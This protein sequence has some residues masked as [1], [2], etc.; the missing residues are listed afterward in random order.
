M[1]TLIRRCTDNLLVS[2]TICFIAGASAAFHL[3]AWWP[4]SPVRLAAVAIPLSLLLAA[5]LFLRSLRP[6][7]AL[8]AFFLAG[9]AHTHWALQPVDDP[10]HIAAFA[11][12]P[13]KVTLVGRIL[14]LV[15]FNGEQTRWVLDSEAL[16]PHNSE[17]PAGFR[18]ILGKVRLAVPGTLAQEFA[19]GKKIMVMA[20]LDRIRNYQTPGA[21]D[22]RLQMATQGIHCSGWIH[23]P[24]EILLVAEPLR[25]GWRD[26]FFFP[27]RIRQQA[28]EF[29]MARFDRDVAGFYQALLIGSTVNISPHLTEIFKDNGCFH[30]LSISGLHMGLLG[31]FCAVL[32]TWLL[33]R[34]TWLLLRVHVP[35]LALALTAPVLLF[36]TFVAG[37]NVPAVRSLVTALLVLFAVMVRRQRTMVHLIAGAALVVLAMTPLAL[38][39]PSFQLSFAAVLAINLIY[40]RLPLFL[41]PE[42]GSSSSS[43]KIAKAMRVLQS[44]LYVSLAATAGTAPIL[45]YHFNRVSLIGP[46]MNLVIEPLLCLWALPCG[47]LALPLI[48]VFPGLAF[49]LCQ[50]GRPGI[51]L[52]IW[53]SEAVARFPHAS[54]WAITPNAGEIVC[55]YLI[56][57]LL[58]LP[59]KT[60][61]QLV[62]ALGLSLVLAGSF[63]RSLWLPETRQEMTV[64]FLDVGQGTCTLVEL[65]GGGAILID[66]GGYQSEQF[67]PGQ[68]LIAPFLWRQRLWRL[69]GLIITHPHRDH[70]NGLPFIAARFRPQQVIIN[71]DPGEEPDYEALMGTVRTQGGKVRIARAGDVL[72]EGHE[73]KI[74]CLGMNDVLGQGAVGSVNERS[75]VVRLQYKGRSVLFPGDIGIASENRLI[76]AGIALQSDVLL[77]PH[78]GSRHSAGTPFMDAVAPA[79]I[80]VSAGR[81]AQ[82]TH[83]AK[84]HLIRWRQQNI[85]V[86][87]TAQAGTVTART[88]GQDMRITTVTGE[89]LRF[90]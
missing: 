53:L 16:L 26:L 23:S 51:E 42:E 15:E 49:L 45:L 18:P 27:E 38:F 74:A 29:F 37:F 25:S 35:T 3:A 30:I 24:H 60:T 64:S 66:G 88:N 41:T 31:V 9:L 20:T 68:S 77:A 70:Y 81:R 72:Y 61:R 89:N 19:P 39:T 43:P 52:T 34:S 50:I 86:L 12:Q 14:S 5:F 13:T 76:R 58:L 46:V 4:V 85:P 1:E 8:F 71:G 44:L 67:D 32:F 55:Y 87:V 90:D 59:G 40:P 10:H 69:K 47:L 79:L 48:P 80:V 63:T 2:A 62:V 65:P 73:A 56:L 21:F 28:A 6:L 11:A 78:H 17:A 54:A 57:L 82:A 75:L 7:V 22:Y 36:Y 84:E 83:P 33:K